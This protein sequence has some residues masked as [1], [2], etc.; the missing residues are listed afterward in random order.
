[1]T[2]LN[3]RSQIEKIV[4]LEILTL[5]YDKSLYHFHVAHKPDG[6]HD[7]RKQRPRGAWQAQFIITR[8]SFF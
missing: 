1:M 3:H 8:H 4:G 5:G 2:F 6:A 7:W